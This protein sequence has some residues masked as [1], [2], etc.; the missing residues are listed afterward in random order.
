MYD[1][2][3]DIFAAAPPFLIVFA[4]GQWRVATQVFKHSDGVGFI[5]PFASD[6]DL[7]RPSGVIPGATWHVGDNLWETDYKTRIMNLDHPH[8]RRHPARQLWLQWLLHQQQR[9]TSCTH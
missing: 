4:N 1:L 3:R 8:D 9:R 6:T 7:E 2:N 5:E